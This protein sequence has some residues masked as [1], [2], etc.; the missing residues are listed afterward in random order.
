MAIDSLP[1]AVVVVNPDGNIEISNDLAVRIFGLSP[2]L[3]VGTLPQ[4]WLAELHQRVWRDRKPSG[5]G[6]LASAI[7]VQIDARQCF[8]LPKAMPILD[9]ANRFIGSTIVLADVTDLRRL[10]E[11]KN[12]LLAMVSHELKTPLTSLRMILPLFLE[13]KA[14][15]LTH[16]QLDL[17]A[18]ARDDSDRLHRIVENLLDMARIESGKA[19][20]EIRPMV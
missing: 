18:A 9:G 10:D 14:G 13:G 11:M 12:G 7:E 3:H 8:F 16:A 1:D 6:G 15:P 17:L 2:G 5:I 19:L 20:M 4:Q